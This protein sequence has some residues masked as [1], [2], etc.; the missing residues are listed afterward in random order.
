MKSQFYTKIS[1][2]LADP[3]SMVVNFVYNIVKYIRLS[4]FALVRFMHICIE[5]MQGRTYNKM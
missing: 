1:I 4:S 5:Q 3:P 2:G